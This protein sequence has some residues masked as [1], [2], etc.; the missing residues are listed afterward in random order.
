MQKSERKKGNKQLLSSF[1]W[2]RNHVWGGGGYHK[3]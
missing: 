1:W 2:C 3:M